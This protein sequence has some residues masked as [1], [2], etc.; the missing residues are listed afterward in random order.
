MMAQDLMVPQKIVMPAQ[1]GIQSL[2]N[3]LKL[4]DS[5]LRGNDEWSEFPTFCCSIKILGTV[6]SRGQNSILSP[7]QYARNAGGI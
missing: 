6:R 1:A 7:R 3:S 4:L 5:R 2:V